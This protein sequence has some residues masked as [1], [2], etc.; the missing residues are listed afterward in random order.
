MKALSAD[1]RALF[2]TGLGMRSH[3]MVTYCEL[4]RGGHREAVPVVTGGSVDVDRTAAIRRRCSVDL[5]MDAGLVPRTPADLLYPG[6]S[7]V[8]LWRGIDWQD[9]R[10]GIPGSIAPPGVELWALGVFVIMETVIG[11][12]GFQITGYDRAK[13][14]SRNAWTSPYSIA[15]GASILTTWQAVI[16]N[17]WAPAE[18]NI[19]QSTDDT[20]RAMVLGDKPQNDPWDDAQKIGQQLGCE[21][22]VDTGGAFTIRTRQPAD[23]LPTSATYTTGTGTLLQG[24]ERRLDAEKGYNVVQVEGNSPG[25]AP[26]RATISDTNPAS[27]VYIDG[28]YGRVP[29][30]IGNSNADS[31]AAIDRQAQALFT[32]RD[33][34]LESTT[35]EII[36]NPAHEHSDVIS[37][38]WPALGISD[39]YQF[40]SFTVPLGAGDT[41]KANVH[42]VPS[43]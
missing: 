20:L 3:K 40:D 6:F 38:D 30:I 41:M 12:S 34:A 43:G 39:R 24:G 8:L 17:R 13:R 21:S 35:I 36:A 25:N 15:A 5:A 42:R 32:E 26:L 4:W 7:E 28:D 2:T 14:V 33:G 37:L 10:P 27:P 31:Q 1:A 16:A 22:Y 11:E 23:S 29:L 19:E 18:F 9:G